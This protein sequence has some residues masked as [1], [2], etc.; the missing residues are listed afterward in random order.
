[1][2]GLFV[3]VRRENW[4]WLAW[5]TMAAAYGWVIIWLIGGADPHNGLWVGLILIIVS[6]VSFSFIGQGMGA[7]ETHAAKAFAWPGLMLASAASVFLMCV[8]LVRA[9]F[10]VTEWGLYGVLA[11]G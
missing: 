8:V 7:E 3:V 11:A 5:P 1:T 9:E 10:G 4:W 6:A 2:I